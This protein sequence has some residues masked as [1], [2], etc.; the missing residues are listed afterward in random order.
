MSNSLC[1]QLRYVG[2]V[3]LLH[4]IFVASSAPATCYS[5]PRA[6]IDEVMTS[7][8]IPPA[9]K[10]S[11]YKVTKIQSDPVLGQRWVMI[12][13][14]DH[15]EWPALALPA[16]GANAL[17]TPH[18]AEGAFTE[19]VKDAPII[20][21]GEIVRLWRQESLLRIEV[22]GI[23]EESGGLGKTIRVRLLRRNT[24]DQSIPEQLSGV[25]R[26]PSNVEIQP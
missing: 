16:N 10:N 26:G 13:S 20:R 9:L 3:S 7:S 1:S 12:A 4:G 17:K 14:C 5:T 15:P 2:L 22:A 18:D 23:S 6:A 8:F 21:A 25:V 24:D 19:D 11:G